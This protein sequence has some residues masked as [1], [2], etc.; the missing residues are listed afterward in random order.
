MCR[1]AAG[2]KPLRRAVARSTAHPR[3]GTIRRPG[4]RG[5]LHRRSSPQGRDEFLFKKLA[6]KNI[7]LLNKYGVQKIVTPC[8]HCLNTIRNEYPILNG[9]FDVEHHSS[10]LERLIAEG[11]LK[12]AAQARETMTFHDPCYLG[13]YNGVYEEPRQVLNAISNGKVI[14]TARNREN[15]FCCGGGGGM[16]FVEEPGD[17][18]VNR[19]RAAQLSETG[20]EVAAVAC[21]FCMTM[22]E[23]GVRGLG[24]ERPMDVKDIY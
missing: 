17:K 6:E 1:R 21:P 12:P 22:L 14:E 23:D 3:R 9:M 19:Q 2:A 24:S 13:R 18:R 15:S 10:F 20:A 4:Q 16:S 7:A 5:T 8:P 11:K